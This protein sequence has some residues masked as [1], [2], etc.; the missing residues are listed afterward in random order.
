MTAQIETTLGQLVDAEPFLRR[1]AALPLRSKDIPEGL[2][3]RTKYHIAKLGR[4]VAAETRHFTDVQAEIFV[5]LG[6][7]AGQRVADL[8]HGVWADYLQRI[9]PFSALQVQIPWAPIQSSDISLAL[10]SDLIGLGPLC[11]VV[12]Q[13]GE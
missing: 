12:E 5:T 13:P 10:A 3:P 11:D 6:I 2:T 1:V 7:M 8:P 9:G 4:L